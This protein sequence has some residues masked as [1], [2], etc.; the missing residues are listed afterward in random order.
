MSARVLLVCPGRGTYTADD[1]GVLARHAARSAAAM[2]LVA[3]ADA[4]RARDGSK[5]ISELDGAPRFSAALHMAGPNAGPLIFGCSAVDALLIPEDRFHA[6]A[7][8]G[9]SM[10]WYTALH[11]AGALDFEAGFELVDTM[12]KSQGQRIRGGQIIIPWVDGDWRPDRELRR[13]IL[14]IC[15]AVNREV[16][17]CALSIDLGGYLVLAGENEALK[18]LFERLPAIR[19]GERDYPF[20]LAQHAAFHTDLMEAAAVFGHQR[21]MTLPFAAPR[22]PLVDGRGRVHHP[23]GTDLDRLFDYTLGEQVLETF[24]FSASIRC[25]MREFAP[26]QII[27]LGPG[28]TLGGAIAQCLILEGWQ[29]LHDRQAFVDR[30][31]SSE[32]ILLAMGRDDQFAR[33]VG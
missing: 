26:D 10:G 23:L 30:Q 5:A 33:V 1:L 3:R 20:Q 13:R 24:D 31:K 7:V 15:A 27:L 12:S 18:A 25:A 29:G 2:E 32:P 21:L 11:V 19:Q 16:A 14:E 28:S 8:C 22:I 17:T 6:V 9:N 4:I